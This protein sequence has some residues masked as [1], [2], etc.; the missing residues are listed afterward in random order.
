MPNW[1]LL[2]LRVQAN[3][4]FSK[5]TITQIMRK[6]RREEELGDFLATHFHA[7]FSIT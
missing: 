4:V 7:P 2:A 1:Y 5:L 3:G 6:L